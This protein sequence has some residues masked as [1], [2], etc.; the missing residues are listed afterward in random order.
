MLL[1]SIP[2]RLEGADPI[3]SSEQGE[4]HGNLVGKGGGGWDEKSR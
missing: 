1:F 2:I 4:C 3:C